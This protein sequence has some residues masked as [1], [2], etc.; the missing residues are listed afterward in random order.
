LPTPSPSG[1]RIAFMSDR[2]GNENIYRMN[3][4]DGTRQRRLTESAAPDNLP[5][6]SP[7][8]TRI[9]F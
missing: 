4:R 6:Y 3:A 7:D 2:D 1:T 5:A 8:G 9:A